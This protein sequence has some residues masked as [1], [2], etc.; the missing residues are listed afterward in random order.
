VLIAQTLQYTTWTIIIAIKD[1][2]AIPSNNLGS[3][4]SVHTEL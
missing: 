4:L 3:R 1:C 2:L